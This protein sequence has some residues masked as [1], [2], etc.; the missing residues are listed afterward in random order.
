MNEAHHTFLT[1]WRRSKLLVI[2]LKRCGGGLSVISLF[3]YYLNNAVPVNR[4]FIC[5]SY[6]SVQTRLLNPQ[7]CDT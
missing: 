5:C 3:N 7:Y 2:L 4:G 1:Y 6:D